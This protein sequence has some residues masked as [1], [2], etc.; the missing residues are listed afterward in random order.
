MFIVI[1]K[2]I[3]KKRVGRSSRVQLRSQNVGHIS[4]AQFAFKDATGLETLWDVRMNNLVLIKNKAVKA[5][6][7]QAAQLAMTAKPEGCDYTSAHLSPAKL[8]RL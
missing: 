7:L 5:Q 3:R 8:A 4:V 1:L 2:C 6:R